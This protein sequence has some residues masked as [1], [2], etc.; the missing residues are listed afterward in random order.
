MEIGEGG[1][2]HVVDFPTFINEG[3]LPP[4]R[5]RVNE[6]LL[7]K[8]EDRISKSTHPSTGANETGTNEKRCIFRLHRRLKNINSKLFEPQVIAL[9]PYHHGKRQLQNMEELKW[10]CLAS[11][12]ESRKG[13]LEE[14]LIQLGQLEKEVRECYSDS[15]TI[16]LISSD[17]L[18]QMMVVDGC[19][20]LML[21]I[22]AGR[23]LAVLD[24]DEMFIRHYPISWLDMAILP[25]IYRDLL[26]LENQIPIPSC[27]LKTLHKICIRSPKSLFVITMNFLLSISVIPKSRNMPDPLEWLHLLDLVRSIF[28]SRRHNKEM[29]WR[30]DNGAFGPISCVTKLRRAGIKVNRHMADSF[31]DVKFKNGVIEMPNINLDNAM[32]SLLVNCVA[33]EQSCNISKHFSIYATLLDYA[34]STLL[35]TSTI[36]VTVASLTISLG[37][38]PTLRNSSITW[39]RT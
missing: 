7:A 3:L 1:A 39:A 11:F 4:R 16:N 13:K 34:L 9:G 22:C 10:Q 32:C 29:A 38:M 19:F 26:L 31:L 36:S 30:T 37:P 2:T 23:H 12:M 8:M 24:Q 33:F 5:P 20:I 18:L 14:C 21:F 27:V 25:K 15:E 35:G 17:E 6:G 28:I